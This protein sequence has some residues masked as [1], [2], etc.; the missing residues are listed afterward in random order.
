MR[1]LI[2]SALTATALLGAFSAAVAQNYD[3][4][5]PAPDC[6]GFANP[7]FKC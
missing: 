1:K 5:H 3:Y 7:G 6:K 2:I 4:W